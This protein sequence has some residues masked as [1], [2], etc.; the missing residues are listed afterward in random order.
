MASALGNGYVISNSDAVY[1]ELP[2]RHFVPGESDLTRKLLL[3][4]K[5]SGVFG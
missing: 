4:R 2:P 1:Y 3:R 5:P